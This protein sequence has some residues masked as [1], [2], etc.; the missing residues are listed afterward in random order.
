MVLEI[1]NYGEIDLDSKNYGAIN[2]VID[3]YVGSD[4]DIENYAHQLSGDRY[5]ETAPKKSRYV[6]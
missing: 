2:M 1:E 6:L 5:G 4:L 3:Q